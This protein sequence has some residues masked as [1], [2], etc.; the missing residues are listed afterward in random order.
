MSTGLSN[1]SPPNTAVLPPPLMTAEQLLAIP[2]DQMERD[3]IRGQLRERPM[4][5]R[6]RFHAATEAAIAKL[7]GNWSDTQAEPRGTVF[8][9]EVGCILRREPDTTVG[10]D[11]AYVSAEMM[12]RQTGATTM[13][14]GAPVLAVEV[15]S[16]SET[17][18][19][20][21]EKINSYLECGVEIVWLVDPS[22]QTV[23]VHERGAE[24][25]LYNREKSF[26]HQRLFPGLNVEVR[27]LFA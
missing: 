11:V 27:T 9:G 6:N 24:P 8:S 15:L 12:H 2:D 22:F 23:T 13:L 19:D 4:T 3:L 7:L 16:P 17:I 21:H 14:E 18:Q 1:D 25:E 5:K 26:S 20:L 10:I